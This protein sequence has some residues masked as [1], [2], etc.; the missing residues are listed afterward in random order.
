MIMRHYLPVILFASAL[1]VGCAGPRPVTMT[2]STLRVSAVAE[3]GQRIDVGDFSVAAPKGEGWCLGAEGSQVVAFMMH[4]LM[5]Q[6][7]E[8]PERSMAL[9][10]VVMTAYK[11]RHG[12]TDLENT[13]ELQQFV[14]EWVTQGLKLKVIES[15]LIVGDKILPR[16]TLVRSKVRPE[17]SSDADCVGYDFVMEER[18]NP[19]APKSVLINTD[20]GVI[21]HHPN[22][23]DYLV[24]MSLSERY[25]RGKQIDPSLFQKL[26]S[27]EAE[28]FFESLEFAQKG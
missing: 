26:K 21:C 5:G 15:E 17:P 8:K 24:V 10:T 23:P 27:Q 28:P 1:L 7:I 4:P 6:Y 9:N 22:A 13:D 3:P 14:E 19:R 2:C 18:D 20:H 25:E 16:F 12:G 11:I